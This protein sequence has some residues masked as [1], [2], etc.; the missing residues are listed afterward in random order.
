MIKNYPRLIQILFLFGI[1]SLF[2]STCGTNTDTPTVLSPLMFLT[3]PINVPQLIGVIPTEEIP[4]SG[5]DWLGYFNPNRPEYIVKY[6]VTNTEQ[7]FIG[8][9]LYVTTQTPT[10]IDTQ[11]GLASSIYSENGILP[12]FPHLSLENSTSTENIKRRKIAWRVP[13]PGIQYFQ[14]CEMYTFTLR[15][16]LSNVQQSSNPSFPVSACAGVDPS[17][18]P[19]GSSCNPTTCTNSACDIETRKTCPVGTLCN[20]CTILESTGLPKAGCECPTGVTTDLYATP[21]ISCNR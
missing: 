11:T 21:A 10:L 18:C 6:F 1:L 8:Y 19:A 16:D 17:K 15:A 3:N 14:K 5:N 4:T 13:P 12:S 7:Q 9:N 20:P 2:I